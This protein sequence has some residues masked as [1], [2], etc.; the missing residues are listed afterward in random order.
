MYH[1]QR[2]VWIDGGSLWTPATGQFIST[3]CPPASCGS[4]TD[5]QS[6][7]AIASRDQEAVTIAMHRN[8]LRDSASCK[9][10][11]VNATEFDPTWSKEPKDWT[12]IIQA[13]GR[14]RDTDLF[15]SAAVRSH[16]RCMRWKPDSSANSL[17][18]RSVG[19]ASDRPA[20]PRDLPCGGQRQAVLS[21]SAQ[22]PGYR[23]AGSQ[24]SEHLRRMIEVA[25]MILQ[26]ILERRPHHKVEG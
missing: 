23:P 24:P 21:R 6:S 20:G 22:G 25:S 10:T 7:P 11:I 17:Q 14:H 12:S 16:R 4:L 13:S 8:A 5:R 2:Q 26:H 15:P 19:T 9:T 3:N 18:M 1:G